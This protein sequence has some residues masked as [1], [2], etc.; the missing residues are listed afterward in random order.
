VEGGLKIL[1]IQ[2]KRVPSIS[3]MF[4]ELFMQIILD[5]D[6]SRSSKNNN[7]VT[8]VES[9]RLFVY[10]SFEGFVAFQ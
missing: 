10:A 6:L 9:Q 3:G 1:C 8:D 5:A 2:R 4:V 7:S